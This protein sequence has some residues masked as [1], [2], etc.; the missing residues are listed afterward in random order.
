MVCPL[1]VHHPASRDQLFNC[2]FIFNRSLHSAVKTRV[3]IRNL[4]SQGQE[5]VSNENLTEFGHDPERIFTIYIAKLARQ[6]EEVRENGETASNAANH[7]KNFPTVNDSAFNFGDDFTVLP[8]FIETDT[9]EHLENCRK[10]TRK[11]ADAVAEF[12]SSKGLG[13]PSFFLY[14]LQV[15]ASLNS[16]GDVIY[17]RALCWASYR[18]TCKVKMV[19]QRNSP[20]KWLLLPWW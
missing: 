9:L 7:F 12:A 20:K 8:T 18:M 14:D 1:G 6:I 19:V 15:C 16:K 17:L 13:M 2:S 10:N 5:P 11:S 3:F 4:L